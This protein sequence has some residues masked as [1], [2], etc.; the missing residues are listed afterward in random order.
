MAVTSL[1]ANSL[2]EILF[3]LQMQLKHKGITSSKTLLKSFLSA[4]VDRSGFL[5]RAEFESLLNKSGI[6]LSRMDVNYLMRHFDTNQDGRISFNEFYAALIPELNA[7]RSQMVERVW[8]VLSAGAEGVSVSTLMANLHVANHPAVVSGEK[9]ETEVF[10]R[11]AAVFE[12]GLRGPDAA[13]RFSDFLKASRE[14]SA[15]YPIDDNSFVR[16]FESVWGVKEPRTGGREELDRAEIVIKEKIRLRMK[17]TETEEQA[18][19]KVFKFVDLDGSGQVQ[20][21]EFTEA[22]KRIGVNLTD[23]QVDAFMHKYDADRSGGLDY[24]EFCRAVGGN[25]SH[26]FTKSTTHAFFS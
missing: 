5:D 2:K 23:E 12:A 6:F 8:A 15:A 7:R 21:H 16:V 10:G 20:S 11:F 22:M 14:I 1:S 24:S 13:V 26:L 18:L 3:N 9:T 17:P 19:V 25:T 4:D